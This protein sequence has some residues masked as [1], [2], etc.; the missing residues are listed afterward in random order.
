MPKKP[1]FGSIRKRGRIFWIR[2]YRDGRR[3]DESSASQKYP[4]AER[5]LRQRHAEI[6]AGIHADPRAGRTFGN[7]FLDDLLVDYK[8][9]GTRYDWAEPVVRV[10]LR[11]FFGAMRASSVNKALAQRY[12]SEAA[13]GRRCERNH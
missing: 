4:D 10:R 13:G 2:Y 6:F 5:L 9:S 11:P 7:A 1:Q 3:F 8:V 12:I